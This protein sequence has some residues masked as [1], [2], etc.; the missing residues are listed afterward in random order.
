M[1]SPTVV[2]SYSPSGSTTQCT[3]IEIVEDDVLEFAVEAFLI[4]ATASDPQTS[5]SVIANIEESIGE[6][7]FLPL[8]L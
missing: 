7:T 6:C 3:D 8:K 2:L 5:I 1:E 4:T